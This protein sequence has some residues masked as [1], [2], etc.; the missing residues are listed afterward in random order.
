MRHDGFDLD[1]LAAAID[2]NTRVIYI[3]NPNN[4]TGTL[5]S[6][7]EMDRFLDRVPGHVIVI[8]DEAYYDFAQYF[9]AIRRVNYSHAPRQ[10]LIRAARL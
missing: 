1:A 9:A 8:L 2:Q 7:E 6:A 3:S 4:P 10:M 5:V